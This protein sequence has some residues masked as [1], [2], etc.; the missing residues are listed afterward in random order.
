MGIILGVWS[1][2]QKKTVNKQ[3]DF[4]AS[5]IG[6][7]LV[8][9]DFPTKKLLEAMHSMPKEEVHPPLFIF[10]GTKDLLRDIPNEFTTCVVTEGITPEEDPL[11]AVRH[12]KNSSIS[13][14]MQM[15]AKHELDA[16]ISAGN[17]GAI[18]ASAS[19]CLPM[20]P[21]IDRP[22]LM[23]LIP[24]KI[25]P[26]AVLD[27]GANVHFKAENLLQFALMGIAYQKARGVVS[28]T[29]GLLNIGEEKQKG[30]KEVRKAYEML[31]KLNKNAPVNQPIF[32][33][34]VEGRDVFHGNMDVMIT[35]G[36]TGN[37]FLK[38]SEGI[39]GFIL[40]QLQNLGPIESLPGLKSII[41]MLRHRLHYA[42][43][44]GA[45]LCGVEGIVFKCHQESS[46]DA[47]IHSIKSADR[48]VKHFFLE[49]LKIELNKI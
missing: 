19:L 46:P 43:Y 18:M 27:V 36:F 28:P 35:D 13:R 8:G 14:A 10:F 29:V 11:T 34:N 15:L 42:E 5:R 1:F 3:I 26:I 22:A 20:L 47:F 37:V 17:T 16:F 12:K 21:G 32:V 24:T 38:T 33:G 48:L 9:C 41:Q 30:T 49:K 6:I 44:P 4:K 25:E 23:V 7:D 2:K 39:A 31:Q 45:I 40:D